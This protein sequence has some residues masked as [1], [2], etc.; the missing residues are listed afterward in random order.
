MTYTASPRTPTELTQHPRGTW[1]AP[2]VEHL[3]LDL[4]SGLDRGGGGG[5][6]LRSDPQKA[7]LKKN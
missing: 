6:S 3:T 1:L 5:L 7:Y 2:L 4:Q